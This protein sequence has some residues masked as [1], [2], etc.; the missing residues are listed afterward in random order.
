MNVR[1]CDFGLLELM[2]EENDNVITNTNHSGS[3]RY[4][5]HELVV[6]D[7]VV[8]PTMAG[9]IWALACVGLWVSLFFRFYL[10]I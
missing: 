5:A 3:E 1:L 9:D 10:C 6:A 2:L 8:F 7:D 4:L